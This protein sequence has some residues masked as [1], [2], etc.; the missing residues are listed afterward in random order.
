M[1]KKT[2]YCQDISS[3]S[4]NVLIHHNC[5]QKLSKRFCGFWQFFLRFIWKSKTGKMLIMILDTKN[6]VRSLTL[7][8]FK[9]CYTDTVIETVW[10]W[11]EDREM[12]QWN[13]IRSPEV[14]PC[15]IVNS[16]WQNCKN[17]CNRAQRDCSTNAPITT[18][19]SYAKEHGS[20]YKLFPKITQNGPLNL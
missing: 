1:D 3:S 6:K 5:N 19:H 13:T 18:G 9:T 12:Y 4:L 8:G 16:V 20:R 10:Y 11:W 7:L 2:Q 17:K 14:Q 15:N